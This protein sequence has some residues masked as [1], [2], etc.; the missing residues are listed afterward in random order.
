LADPATQ[1]IYDPAGRLVAMIPGT[2]GNAVGYIYDSAGNILSIESVPPGQLA[3][4][5][6]GP[7]VGA[8]GSQV[9]IYGNGFS[10]T[11]G[12][13]TVMFNGVAATV[14]SATANQLVVEIPSGVTTGPVSV[15]V[16]E[17]TI[18]SQQSFVPVQTVSITSVTP[19]LVDIGG[20]V[21]VAGSGLNPSAGGT[22]VELGSTQADITSITNSNIEFLAP[23]GTSGHV[24]VA[25]ENGLAV[26]AQDLLILPQGTPASSVESTDNLPAGGQQA[27]VNISSP[28]K[29]GIFYFDATQGQYLTFQFNSIST[30]DGAPVAYTLYSPTRQ[31]LLSGPLYPGAQSLHLPVMPVSGAYM[32]LLHPMGSS[33]A[34]QAKLQ[35]DPVITAD[36]APLDISVTVPGQGIRAVYTAAAGNNL[37]LG[38]TNPSS[39][40]GIN[41]GDY[42][43]VTI[44]D[45]DG[46][47]AYPSAIGNFSSGINICNIPAQDGCSI[48]L[49]FHP[50]SGAYLVEISD[51][52]GL[53]FCGNLTLSTDLSQALSV[54]S[55]QTVTTAKPG[56]EQLFH[57]SASAGQTLSLYLAPGTWN[58]SDT[59]INANLY[60]P[61]GILL[62]TIFSSP[63]GVPLTLDLPNL[64]AGTYSVV[65]WPN[66]KDGFGAYTAAEGSV[67]ATLAPGVTNALPTDGTPTSIHTTVPGQLTHLTF[68]A[69]AGQS[70]AIALTN[71]S[72]S[73]PAISEVTGTIYAPDG[74]ELPDGVD[75]FMNGNTTCEGSVPAV[76]QT[77]TYTLVIG[78][79]E[80]ADATMSMSVIVTKDVAGTMTVGTAVNVS[81][82]QMGQNGAFKFTTTVKQSL[83]LH[84]NNPVISETTDAGGMT[85]TV[86]DSAGNFVAEVPDTGV[87]ASVRMANLKAGTYL[88]ILSPDYPATGTAQ[89]KVGTS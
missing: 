1:Y 18:S 49:P 85:A 12:D 45:P 55:P 36:G 14:V 33:A 62:N 80:P 5:S 72:F 2:G 17:S 70:L 28:T 60:S 77:G 13:N 37:A 25:T 41:A 73:D 43:R 30:P 21:T 7:D 52:Q 26:S 81:L 39:T 38:L 20:V 47:T 78:Q 87:S 63:V 76:R 22:E 46:V 19:L 10:L 67:Q 42:F 4:F 79:S 50:T 64:S 68:T 15:T 58:P 24:T 9:T 31:V 65:V 44:T 8:A 54:G 82:L 40:A 75:C 89:L 16:G 61:A 74:S 56:Q 48:G 71:I 29:W 69:T 34:L 3:I 59:G 23:D 53:A 84:L 83:T 86:Y 27:T 6:V 35:T 66:S 51:G 32:L 11:A 57:F 88:V